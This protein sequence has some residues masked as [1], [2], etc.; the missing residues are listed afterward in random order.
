MGKKE[1]QRQLRQAGKHCKEGRHETD[2]QTVTQMISVMVMLKTFP[3]LVI[4]DL[5][6]ATVTLIYFVT[7]TIIV[8]CDGNVNCNERRREERSQS[9]WENMIKFGVWRTYQVGRI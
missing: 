3:I 8:L 4:Q 5:Y 2:R 6:C 7:V 9:S 1:N